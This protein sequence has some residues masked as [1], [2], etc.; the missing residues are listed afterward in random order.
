MH[1]IS[2]NVKNIDHQLSFSNNIP[3]RNNQKYLEK[4]NSVYWTTVNN[5]YSKSSKL[6]KT[7]YI[8]PSLP[9]N[10]WMLK[11][12][13][14]YRKINERIN[15]VCRKKNVKPWIIP[16]NKK[17]LKY[18]EHFV[19]RGTFML[20]QEHRL[21]YCRNAKVGTTTWMMLFDSLMNPNQKKEVYSHEDGRFHHNIA[22]QYKLN[23]SSLTNNSYTQLSKKPSFIH[24]LTNFLKESK[25]LT[26]SFVRHPFERL[27]SAYKNKV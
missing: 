20:D 17:N 9:E 24:I 10:E 22:Q 26:F 8:L 13:R 15:E 7:T 27:V 19:T 23:M 3:G 21:G 6:D 2:T 18:I 1:F 4:Q 5:E 11:M 25:I 14:K 16:K 12:E